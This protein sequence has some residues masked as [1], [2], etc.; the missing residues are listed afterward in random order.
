MSLNHV[1]DD[2]KATLICDLTNKLFHGRYVVALIVPSI[3]ATSSR[4]RISIFQNIP[5][6]DYHFTSPCTSI[7]NIKT[8]QYF[9]ERD[10][11]HAGSW[12]RFFCFLMG[13]DTI[14]FVDTGP[15]AIFYNSI[16]T[17]LRT[18]TVPLVQCQSKNC[19][20]GCDDIRYR[21]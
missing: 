18:N 12:M 19:G 17:R 21:R 20:Y 9:E 6:P 16:Q 7:T 11:L 5:L 3:Y 8:C 14:A 2:I 4:I 10:S 13:S 1:I 15:I